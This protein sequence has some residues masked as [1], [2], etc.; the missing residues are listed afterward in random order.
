MR[1]KM[2][3]YS[4]PRL[5]LGSFLFPTCLFGLFFV[6]FSHVPGMKSAMWFHG[7]MFSLLIVFQLGSILSMN[8]ERKQAQKTSTKLLGGFVSLFLDLE[9]HELNLKTNNII[10]NDVKEKMFQKYKT[11]EQ[12][13]VKLYQE[14]ENQPLSFLIMF[15]QDVNELSSKH[16]N[17]VYDIQREIKDIEEDLEREIKW[18]KI[19]IEREEYWNR[20]R[21]NSEARWN[22]KKT[23]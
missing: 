5:L 15:K 21:K 6:L 8:R 19:D 3:R 18:R 4:T 9:M 11:V 17:D 14:I 2:P 7:I 1:K 22:K 20:Q 12:K 13:L 16:Y 10:A 23:G